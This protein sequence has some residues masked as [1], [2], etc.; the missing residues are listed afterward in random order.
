[1]SDFSA[2]KQQVNIAEFI[3]SETGFSTKRVGRLIDLKEC[4]FCHG[5]NCF[6]IDS[7]K[8]HWTCYQCADGS[9]SHS[10]NGDIFDFIQ[11]Y[12]GCNQQEALVYIAQ[13]YNFQLSTSDTF[14]AADNMQKIKD[15]ALSILKN[16]T[17]QSY[18]KNIQIKDKNGQGTQTMTFEQY[19]TVVRKHS[20]DILN[21][22]GIVVSVTGLTEEL[23]SQGYKRKYILKAGFCNKYGKDYF[24]ESLIL[25]P[26]F[27][28]GRLSHFSTKDPTGTLQYQSKKDHRN[29]T[30]LFYNMDALAVYDEIILV[31]GE[32]DVL[33]VMDKAKHANVI[34]LIGTPS[35][36][37]LTHLK[38]T[39]YNKTIYLCLDND[40]PGKKYTNTIIRFLKGS[41]V[42]VKIIEF[43]GS[44]DIDE[45]LCRSKSPEREFKELLLT[46]Y[47]A[48]D[49]VF[50][51]IPKTDGYY[52][53]KTRYKDV[54]EENVSN[55]IF[56]VIHQIYSDEECIRELEIVDEKGSKTK[57]KPFSTKDL[58]TSQDFTRKLL[59]C[60]NYI[61]SGST[62]DL[63]EVLQFELTRYSGKK[64]QL[65]DYVGFSDQH[66]L[67]VFG[68]KIIKD[69]EEYP[70]DDNGITWIS[71]VEGYKLIALDASH[72]MSNLPQ[73]K[74]LSKEKAQQLITELAE[75]LM[76]NL[77][78]YEG[79]LALGFVKACIYSDEIFKEFGFFP[80]LNLY[81][82]H[83]SG[84]N[85]LAN[86]LLRILGIPE[87]EI[88][89]LPSITTSVGIGRKAAY[90]RSLPVWCDEY[91]NDKK[92]TRFNGF[93]RNGYNRVGR[94]F[95]KKGAHGT[96]SNK[97]YC[98]FGISGEERPEDPAL[99]ERF[100]YIHLSAIKRNDRYYD[101]IRLAMDDLPG[102]GDYWI[103][104]K[105]KVDI[106]DVKLKISEVRSNF[107]EKGIDPR[108]AGNYA[109]PTAFSLT[110]HNNEEFIDWVLRHIIE[111]K[112]VNQSVEYVSL[113]L[114][115][116]HQLQV[117]GQL[118]K[119]YIH[120]QDSNIYIWFSS[121]Y[122]MFS[123]K[124]RK[125][126]QESPTSNAILD[127]FKE[128]AYY[129]NHNHA[130]RMG[131]TSTLRK[132]LV[133]NQDLGPPIL[134]S[135]CEFSEQDENK[136]ILKNP[137][138]EI[139]SGSYN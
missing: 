126:G 56:K 120:V 117:Q 124:R 16:R 130:K 89:S 21:K 54:I 78:G 61:F 5:H 92:I 6:R 37:Q 102:I 4:P 27:K 111:S 96:F 125:Q 105:A 128:E 48:P 20:K 136:V 24:A 40:A 107:I 133:L 121:V 134:R 12:R 104:E 23:V 106:Q 87:T 67:W 18:S 75:N 66:N 93:F 59:N 38:E 119:E 138:K 63:L 15:T 123:E 45:F 71:D 83:Q 132:C 13:K 82:K 33:S 43:N 118:D 8:K 112:E 60:G 137:I 99:R 29:P 69:G 79:L 19:L 41:N 62:Q 46:A 7:D 135:I 9:A 95:G 131:S 30:C 28:N 34:G 32:N 77:G 109:I 47:T 39:L 68:N 17:A 98:I 74:T 42:T 2:L 26:H 115:S 11:K 81:G 94:S 76:E 49:K 31:E 35:D 91:R 101:A 58:S 64:L 25:Y 116:I 114:E 97:I 22:M 53:I 88:E 1:M 113:F 73:L 10:A 72:K 14:N 90:F 127:L 100:V 51:V 139:Y 84:K 85:V 3:S 129:V 55:F 52:M 36:E 108:L 122:G 50:D 110:I 70:T 86:I 80:G 57:P 65:L 103:K 44:K